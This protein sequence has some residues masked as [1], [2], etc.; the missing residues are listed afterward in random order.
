MS[1]E[2]WK[3]LDKEYEQQHFKEGRH[4]SQGR[5]E[6]LKEKTSCHWV[7]FSIEFWS[8]FHSNNICPDLSRAI[9]V[10]EVISTSPS[11]LLPHH[12]FT[13]H[14]NTY[15][16]EVGWETRT[17]HHLTVAECQPTATVQC[18]YCLRTSPV[19]ILEFI[20]L[21]FSKLSSK[22][23]SMPSF[24]FLSEPEFSKGSPQSEK[25]SWQGNYF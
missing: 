11:S 15:S 16:W 8:T 18:I 12:S 25:C 22:V 3:G 5:F 13:P 10:R 24:T 14:F 4:S 19:F 7:T 6:S 23:F 21:I 2:Q 20:I 17:K 9:C 1:E